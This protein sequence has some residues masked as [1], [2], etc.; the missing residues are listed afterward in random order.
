MSGYQ[1]RVLGGLAV[2]AAVLAS[3][4]GAQTITGRISG[5]VTD[6]AGAIVPGA[7]AVLTNQASGDSRRL[8]TNAG[9]LFVFPALQPGV[10]DVRVELPGFQAHERKGLNLSANQDLSIGT[11]VLK[12][13]ELSE[14]ITVEAKGAAVETTTSARSALI[15]STQMELVA[16]RSRDVVALLKV[17]PGV[18]ANPATYTES[19]SL[20]GGFGTR[21]PNFQGQREG[22]A[23]FT[24]DGISGND[25]GTPAVFSGTTNFDAISEVKVQL[26]NY[27]AE[28]GHTGG[29]M[30]NIVTK[31]G[32]KEFH[33]GAYGYLRDDSLNANDFFNNKAGLKKPTYSHKTAGFTLGGPVFIPGVFNEGKEKLFFF[34][35]FE[36]L[37]T[38][39]PQPLRQ[40]TVPTSLERSGDFSQSLDQTG[41]LIVIRDPLTGQPF[42]GNVIPRNRLNG[43]GLALLGRFPLPNALDRSLTAGAYNYTF[44]ESLDVPKRQHLLRLDFH[45]SEK[46][47]LF[48][49]GSAWLADNQGFAVPAGAANWGMVGLHYTFT[50]KVALAGYTHTFNSK[51]VN[52][53]TIGYRQ[54][55]ENGPPL[56][57]AGLDSVKASTIGYNLGQFFPSS[58]PLGIM[59]QVGTG[60]TGFGGV[61][62]AA[63]LT[64]DGRF[65]L[66]GKDTLYSVTNDITFVLGGGH[67]V[68][69]GGYFEY[70]KNI[71]GQTA[72]FGG[73]YLFDRDTAN[74]LDT[75]YAYS[76]AAL[77]IFRQYEESSTRPYTLGRSNIAEAYVQ[78]T[79]KIGKKLTLDVGLRLGYYTQWRQ[80]DGNAA[81]FS[82]ERFDPKAVPLLYRPVLVG[83]RRLAQDPRTGQTFPAVLIGAYVPGTGNP[84]NGM[85][86]ASDSSYPDG[87]RDQESVRPEPR[88][89]F[90]FDPW[91][92][93]KTAVRGAFG[94]FYNFRA[95]DGTLRTLTQQPPS[96]LNPRVL[97]GT[98]DTLLSSNGTLFPANVTGIDRAAKTPKLYN[99]TLGVQRDIGWGTV[100]DIA[101]VA[102]LGRNLQQQRNINLVPAGARFLPQNQDPTR[103]GNPLPDVFFA[104]YPG[105]GNINFNTWNGT[106][107]YQAVQVQLN[108]RFTKGLQFGF[109]YTLSRV[110]DQ[111]DTDGGTV[112]TYLDRDY[113][114][115]GFD[116]THVFVFNY[117]WDLPKGSRLL[118]GGW[119]ARGL[120]DGWQFSGITAIASGAPLSITYTTA[121]GADT[122]GGGDSIRPNINGSPN[123]SSG[124][125]SFTHWFDTS[126]FS[127]PAKGEFGNAPRNP[128]RGPGTHN[129]DMSFFKNFRMG[130]RA[131]LQF[132]WE[133]YNVFNHPQGLAV[134]TTARFDA[135]GNQTNARFG[136]VISSRTPRIM[137]GSVRFTF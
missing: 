62:N 68:K 105:I 48:V 100:V 16:V 102:S 56:T 125:R 73:R 91:A 126:V 127:R 27:R 130:G 67:T 112:S 99:F 104:P 23:T 7:T 5:A 66:T 90:S 96:Q 51:V 26:N 20:G 77:G 121:D 63:L 69:A 52:E 122:T 34:Y 71:E 94:V 117:T 72:V 10:Y 57:D 119:L 14:T 13:G 4:A 113:D 24:V 123:L 3:A 49:R 22:W 38:L 6:T 2:L 1:W 53:L 12:A 25:L 47:S 134:D 42:P 79:W 8:T 9:G 33:G 70:A 110:K 137:Q 30:V 46:D 60:T 32:S 61:P 129:W 84:T 29:A 111:T 120:L 37:K 103:P 40:V 118:G 11:V 136:Q 115:A 43:N 89:G 95:L 93:G 45:P 88:L 55:T 109:A 85:V 83:G 64:Y 92:D 74:P 75:N 39:T 28:S 131:A 59:P 44:Q 128:V 114:V 132:R 31:S 54:S 58:N 101:G 97:Y 15:S 107:S 76:N 86:L 78:D 17:L 133:M 106:S 98:M 36:H 41:K 35:S 80:I 82:L 108:R 135:A 124:D 19:E 116:Q 81:A 87:F 50:D 18:S 65:P 21:A